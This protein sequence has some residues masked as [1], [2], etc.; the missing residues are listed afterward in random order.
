MRVGLWALA[1]AIAGMLA[2][3]GP[4]SAQPELY[5]VFAIPVDEE[6]ESAVAAREAALS[7]AKAE[8]LDR[9]LRRLTREGDWPRLPQAAALPV[10]ELV[11][12]FTVEEE[13]RSAT[14]YVGRITVRYRGERVR[15]LLAGA[16][17]PFA[18]TPSEPLLVVPALIREGAID[19][20]SEDNPWRRAWLAEAERNT[21]LDLRL[22][23]GDLE[24][25]LVLRPVGLHPPLDALE[26]L[27]ARYGVEALVVAKATAAPAVGGS[28][29]PLALAE[30]QGQRIELLFT[31]Y[32]SW[33]GEVRRVT[34]PVREL[35]GEES[36]RRAV[37]VA[38]RLLEGEWKDATLLRPDLRERVLLRVPLA[39]LA[40]W[41]Q[42][43]RDLEG[44]A[45]V[46]DV[47]LD[48]LSR[49]EAR[50]Q[51]EVLGGRGRLAQLLRGRGFELRSE[52]GSWLLRRVEAPGVR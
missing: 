5:T 25:R 42:I 12:S 38:I 36:W 35:E 17:I 18:L 48:S 40:E 41:V 15:E 49:A 3:P 13:K 22:P 10:E 27:Q 28:P 26:R 32:G 23:L 21:L 33:P 39:G 43:R 24:D 30:P 14:R 50:V 34:L 31:P 52:N 6:A 2:F 9:L 45:E 20:W 7:R 16:G 37:R 1:L 19:Y 8:G 44:L 51:V 11:A 47:A 4:G 46:V 29:V